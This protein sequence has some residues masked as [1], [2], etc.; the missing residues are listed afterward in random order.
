MLTEIKNNTPNPLLV[1]ELEGLLKQAKEG[2]IKSIIY[3]VTLENNDVSG[4]WIAGDKSGVRE[5]ISE[6][7]AIILE[8]TLRIL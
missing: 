5:M 4:G 8:L 3:A 2:E 6:L 7:H 1:E